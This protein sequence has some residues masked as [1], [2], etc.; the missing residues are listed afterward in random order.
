MEDWR[1]RFESFVVGVLGAPLLLPLPAPYTHLP[2]PL[3]LSLY[4]SPCKHIYPFISIL[5]SLYLS[6][7]LA[8]SLSASHPLNA[9]QRL[10]SYLPSPLV[11]LTLS[12]NFCFA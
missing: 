10:I 3:P 7:S 4:L 8:V 2:L 5:P 12:I 1:V 9:H 6:G 11:S